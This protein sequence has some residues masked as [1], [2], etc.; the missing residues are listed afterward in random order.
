MCQWWGIIS[1]MSNF[2]VIETGGKQ[3]C[4]SDNAVI[5]IELFDACEEG[6]TIDFDKVL[7]FDDGSNTDI[8]APYIPGRKVTGMVEKVG[9][10]K[11]IPVIRFRAKSNYRRH[12]GHRQ[13]FCRVRISI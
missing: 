6:K 2:A 11:K 7:L 3:Y 5:D 12:Y 13:P 10:K 4:V 8:G 9:K 1:I